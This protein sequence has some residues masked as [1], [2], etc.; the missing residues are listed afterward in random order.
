VLPQPAEP[1]QAHAEAI[2]TPAS[3]PQESEDMTLQ[4]SEAYL[5]WK[6]NHERSG[7]ASSAIL[8]GVYTMMS[9]CLIAGA[10]LIA[11]HMLHR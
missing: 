10:T 6:E 9:F 3:V 11:R 2:L 7:H 4:Q 5:D 8:L 1:A